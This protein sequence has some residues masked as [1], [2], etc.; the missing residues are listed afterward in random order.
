M[1]EHRGTTIESKQ[2]GKRRMQKK[3]YKQWKQDFIHRLEERIRY[4]PE[5]STKGPI[6]TYVSRGFCGFKRECMTM[7][8]LNR[9]GV[10]PA[11]YLDALYMRYQLGE[12][13][14]ELINEVATVFSDHMDVV[15]DTE[16]LFDYE[17]IKAHLRI[18][19][20]GVERNRNWLTE[21]VS[22]RKGDF[23][24][25][26]YLCF[27]ENDR[28]TTINVVKECADFWGVSKD[29]IMAEARKNEL[30]EPVELVS[31]Y[32]VIDE[33]LE[34]GEKINLFEYPDE[35]PKD[36]LLFV[37]RETDS[38]NGAAVLTRDE[39]LK[40]AGEVLQDDYYIMP[41]SIREVI[42]VPARFGDEM[43]SLDELVREINLKEVQPKEILGNH[44]QYYDRKLQM[45]MNAD[46][47]RRM[48]KFTEEAV[49]E[50]P[51]GEA[52]SPEQ[53]M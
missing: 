5:L 28:Q 25:S 32:G 6:E 22:Q 44:A 17:R 19:V 39:V 23:I 3:N 30:A 15:A 33:F 37:L 11:L 38:P 49:A 16:M 43:E 18:R 29:E 45:F 24:Y 53:T 48:I 1:W 46:E 47:Y 14:E 12:P 41:S 27:N 26:A 7:P 35:M 21:M 10:S 50:E 36:C 51:E 34:C 31:M 13:E 8:N 2:K 9:A 42:L 20:S 52:F 4:D 40:K